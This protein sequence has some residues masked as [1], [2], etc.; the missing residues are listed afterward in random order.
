MTTLT[1]PTTRAI[2]RDAGADRIVIDGVDVT[3]FRMTTPGDQ[4]WQVPD[5]RLIEPFAYG[6]TRLVVPRVNAQFERAGVGDLAFAR[7]GAVVIFQ[8]RYGS[9][10][11]TDYRGRVLSVSASG[12]DLVLDVGGLIEGPAT[13]AYQPPPVYREMGSTGRWMRNALARLGLP[14]GDISVDQGRQV[15]EQGDMTLLA[16]M[17]QLCA[18]STA[19]DGRQRTLMPLEGSNG[20]RWGFGYKD[21]TTVH[22]TIFHDGARA[23]VDVIDDATEKPNV[24]YGDGVNPDGGRWRNSKN[25]GMVPIADPPPFPMPAGQVMTLGTTDADT[26]SGDGVDTLRV[27]LQVF[28]YANDHFTYDPLPYGTYNQQIAD[29]VSALQ[30]DANLPQTGETDAATWA[31]LWNLADTGTSLTDARQMPLVSSGKVDR[32]NYAA[33]GSRIGHNDA[34]DPDA[35]RVD[36]PISFG[37]G[38]EKADARD[39]CR[40]QQARLIEAKWSG[41]IVLDG[42]GGFAGKHDDPST[43]TA[44]DLMTWRDFRPGMNVWLPYFDGGQ[45][46]HVSGIDVTA[47]GATLTV[48]Q[49]ARDFPELSEVLARR[50]ESRRDIRR[51]WVAANRS[52]RASAQVPEWDAELGG[53]LYDAE[54]L[55]GDGWNLFPVAV[56]QVGTINRVNITL[57]KAT[58]F[59]VAVFSRRV[60]ASDLDAV[61]GDPFPV[62]A[63]GEPKWDTADGV[64]AWYDDGTLLYCAGHEKD[65]CGYG[66]Y[67]LR[68]KFSES[69]N[70]TDAPLVGRFRDD[71]AWDYICAPFAPSILYVAIWPLAD[72]NVKAG[73]IFRNSESVV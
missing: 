18:A 28:G 53:L 61:V 46:F 34:Y 39:W 24:W 27:R 12:T 5:Y 26:T 22:A 64:Q 47:T 67:G 38:V 59:A 70:R 44:A 69:G 50:R 56:G 49:A 32:W 29:G 42:W 15:P 19:L 55:R 11:V 35:L 16:W 45:L 43:V 60:Y 52:N 71:S 30:A 21:T 9:A 3:Y 62:N 33:N 58:E 36:R 63:D 14:I 54:P 23:V 65:P 13:L 4:P 2:E 41:R 73:R 6:P 31:A 51:E 17:Q 8:R 72:A 66:T 57:D 37:P 7:A 25:P 48:D 40:A 10:L 68:H 1:F 20:T